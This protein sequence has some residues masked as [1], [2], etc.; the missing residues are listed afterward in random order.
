MDNS[1]FPKGTCDLIVRIYIRKVKVIDS[2]IQM[3]HFFLEL[4]WMSFYNQK[5]RN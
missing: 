5:H 2:G 4:S 3:H 1:T